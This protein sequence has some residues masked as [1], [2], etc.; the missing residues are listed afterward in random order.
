MLHSLGSGKRESRW[1]SEL[2]RPKRA[3]VVG[4]LVLI[5]RGTSP[6]YMVVVRS[7]SKGESRG[8]T[9]SANRRACLVDRSFASQHRHSRKHADERSVARGSVTNKELDR[10]L[11][12]GHRLLDADKGEGLVFEQLRYLLHCAGRRIL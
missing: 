1:Y 5:T 2:Q 8:K 10:Q 9:I 7:H 4:D 11:L 6:S 12:E 3:T